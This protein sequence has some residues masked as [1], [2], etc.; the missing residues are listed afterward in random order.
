[1]DKTKR[2]PKGASNQIYPDRVRK[3]SEKIGP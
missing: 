1:M 3:D 2:W